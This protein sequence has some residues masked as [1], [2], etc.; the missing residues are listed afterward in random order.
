MR[1][2]V[3]VVREVLSQ[4]ATQ[5]RFGHDDHMGP[6]THVGPIRSRARRRRFATGIVAFAQVLDAH[7]LGRGSDGRE[8]AIPI[9]KEIT[10]GVI[11]REGL[12]ELLGGPGGGGMCSDRD[13]HDAPPIVRQDDQHK[14]KSIRHRRDDEEIGGDR[15]AAWPEIGPT[16]AESGATT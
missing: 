3:V 10:R 8:C 13:V 7:A 1:S 2:C 5:S 14:Q 12:T 6:G 11:L 4:D 16:S 15:G 9:V